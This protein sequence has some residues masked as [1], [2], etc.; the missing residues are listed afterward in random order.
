MGFTSSAPG[1]TANVGADDGPTP[2]RRHPRWVPCTTS[3]PGTSGGGYALRTAED[4]QS[5]AHR[6]AAFPYHHELQHVGAVFGS[7]P[8]GVSTAWERSQTI[9]G[10][11]SFAV[12]FDDDPAFRGRHSA[13]WPQA[14]GGSFKRS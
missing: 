3:A 7:A 9:S 6:G 4:P 8:L 14:A 1:G 12:C 5:R 13:R 11:R 10:D 2:F